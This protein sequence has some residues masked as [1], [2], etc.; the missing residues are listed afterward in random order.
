MVRWKRITGAFALVIFAAAAG[1][2]AQDP[3][4]PLTPAANSA[5]PSSP[6]TQESGSQTPAEMPQRIRIGG[7]VAAAALTHQVVPVYPQ[8][9]K[10]A[11]ISGTVMLH[12]IIGKDGSVKQLGI[13]IRT[14]AADEV[15]YGRSP[16]VDL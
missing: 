10:T 3:G 16:P 13:H 6:L 14:A 9:A 8:L 5:Q 15:R 12:C 4:G 7:N 2:Q 1:A 11:H